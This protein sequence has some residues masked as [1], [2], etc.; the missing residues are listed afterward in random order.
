[1]WVGANHTAMHHLS[2][3]RVKTVDAVSK[4]QKKLRKDEKL[5]TKLRELCALEMH[6]LQLN[7]PLFGFRHVS[8][9]VNPFK[10]CCVIS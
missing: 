3:R 8:P 6:Y 7:L 9:F 1:M 10:C 2:T 5:V 4:L